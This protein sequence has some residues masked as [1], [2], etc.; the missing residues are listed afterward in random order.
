MTVLLTVSSGGD[1]RMSVEAQSWAIEL[2]HNAKGLGDSVDSMLPR[3]Q[4][5]HVQLPVTC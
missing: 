4:L 5:E 2:I 3:L 1:G